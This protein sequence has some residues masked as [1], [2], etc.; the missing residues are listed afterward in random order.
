[1]SDL[2]LKYETTKLKAQKFMKKGQLNDYF[3]TLLEL[4]QQKKLLRLI[5]AN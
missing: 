2:I 4:N 1:M 3:N 5:I